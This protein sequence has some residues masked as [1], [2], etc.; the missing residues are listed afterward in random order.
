MQDQHSFA[1]VRIKQSWGCGSVPT[2]S[3][4]ARLTLYDLIIQDYPNYK[5][6]PRR[7]KRD[8]QKGGGG[9]SGTNN[10][11]KTS[12]NNNNNNNNTVGGGGAG[13]GGGGSPKADC[14][15]SKSE[16]Y[17]CGSPALYDSSETHSATTS[18]STSLSRSFTIP[19]PES[20]PSSCTSDVFHSHSAFQPAT[21]MSLESEYL[22]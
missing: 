15:E 17:N 18:L 21:T 4:L 7:K 22:A 14:E 13:G 5:Y 2:Q 6:R 16:Q 20:S 10:N 3:F 19:T 12:S 11:T 9:G 8:G 1:S